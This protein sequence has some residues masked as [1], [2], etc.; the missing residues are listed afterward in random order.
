MKTD[1]GISGST[2]SGLGAVLGD[3]PLGEA[4][5]AARED[6]S[7]RDRIVPAGKAHRCKRS[8][9]ANR[10]QEGPGL[11]RAITSILKESFSR[12]DPETAGAG[13]ISTLTTRKR[14][15]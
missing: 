6:A 12:S 8:F 7:M 1:C 2:G 15:N 9:M 13:S 5:A 14:G 10:N 11:T 3:A 4:G